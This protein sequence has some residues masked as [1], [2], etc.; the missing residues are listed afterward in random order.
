MTDVNTVA[1]RAITAPPLLKPETEFTPG[2]APMLTWVRIADLVV[3]EAYQR[4]IAKA[5]RAN[6]TRIAEAF[7][8]S[9]FAPLIC[10]A[11]EGGRFAIID[12]QHRATAAAT[13]GVESVPAMIVIA[14]RARQAEAFAAVNAQI[15]RLNA[16]QIFKARL[17]S[18]EP[19]AKAVAEACEAAG[20]RIVGTN[21]ESAKMR[22]G[23]CSSV[24]T[25]EI[26]LQRYGRDTLVTALMCVTETRNNKAGIL[27]ESTIK[28]L[29][30]FL[31]LYR[32]WRDAGERLLTAMDGVDLEAFVRTS[33]IE[34]AGT[35]GLLS[36]DVITAQLVKALGVAPGA[37]AAA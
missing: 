5:G 11:V 29:C 25:L 18:G 19:V 14:D 15:T 12:G 23:D 24:R 2:P 37:A 30:E 33:R 4:P 9:K 13:R 31:R 27:A 32:G 36:A 34:A 8:W 28:G 20:V 16:G 22:P 6:I 35:K 26:S 1:L 17:A 3:D 7:D 21:C 10:A